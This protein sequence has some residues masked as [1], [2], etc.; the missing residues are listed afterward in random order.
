[1]LEQDEIITSKLRT[2]TTI[3]VTVEDGKTRMAKIEAMHIN[4]TEAKDLFETFVGY[5]PSLQMVS[6]EMVKNFLY[7]PTVGVKTLINQALDA[8]A[9]GDYKEGGSRTFIWRGEFEGKEWETITLYPY[10][11]DR[12][13]TIT[14]T[15]PNDIDR[16]YNVVID[17]TQR[18][19]WNHVYC[20]KWA[21]YQVLE[22]PV[23]APPSEKSSSDEDDDESDDKYFGASTL[24]KLRESRLFEFDNED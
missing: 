3:T 19:T 22:K 5:F 24:A 7:N 4:E 8:Q 1:M 18:P 6:F 20:P 9:I 23:V 13:I 21:R 14:P 11:G 15:S 17:Y 16:T 12:F 2:E 10:V